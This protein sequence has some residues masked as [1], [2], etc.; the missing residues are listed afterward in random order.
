VG[1]K[2]GYPCCLLVQIKNANRL[3]AMRLLHVFHFPARKDLSTTALLRCG[4][5]AA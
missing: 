2:D 5:F 4:S 1:D 3:N